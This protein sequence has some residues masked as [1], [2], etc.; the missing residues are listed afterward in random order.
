[1]VERVLFWNTDSARIKDQQLSKQEDVRDVARLV[2]KMTEPDTALI[3]RNSTELRRASESHQTVVRM[4]E[5]MR[6]Q[7]CAEL[8]KASIPCVLKALH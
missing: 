2:V 5:A 8:L 3:D 7:T 4:L 1:V 6:T